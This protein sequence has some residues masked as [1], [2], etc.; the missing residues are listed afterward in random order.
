[1]N[2]RFGKC[3]FCKEE[4]KM[5]FPSNDGDGSYMCSDCIDGVLIWLLD[6][7]NEFT[8]EVY[9]TDKHNAAD[10]STHPESNI[11]KVTFL[12]VEK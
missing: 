12:R 2:P 7:G 6:Y 4:H 1:M 3:H 10:R 11:E 8:E 5:I 9:A